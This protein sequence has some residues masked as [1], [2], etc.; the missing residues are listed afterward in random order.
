MV[1]SSRIWWFIKR[2]NKFGR[3]LWVIVVNIGLWIMFHNPVFSWN[4]VIRNRNMVMIVWKFLSQILHYRIP[5]GLIE[6]CNYFIFKIKGYVQFPMEI[7]FTLLLVSKDWPMMIEMVVW[8][9]LFSFHTSSLH[10]IH[11]YLLGIF[12]SRVI[13]YLSS[14]RACTCGFRTHMHVSGSCTFIGFHIRYA[15]GVYYN[16]HWCQHGRGMNILREIPLSPHTRALNT[17]SLC[18]VMNTKFFFLV[19]NCTSN[20]KHEQGHAQKTNH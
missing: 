2:W 9:D 19:N 20:L 7:L 14:V 6:L 12:E 3:F 15:L 13:N 4:L 10:A 1:W 18:L 16:S 8:E 5:L 11:I 17:L